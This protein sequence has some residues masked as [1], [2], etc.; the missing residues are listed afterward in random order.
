VADVTGDGLPDIVVVPAFGGGP[1]IRIFDA[2][3]GQLT[4]FHQVF[5]GTFQGGLTLATGDTGG[6][7]YS[8]VLVGAGE[9]GGPR[10]TLYD[11][12]LNKSI[13]NYFAY[14][15]TLR[16]GVSVSMGVLPG[17]TGADIVTGV[18]AG[19]GPQVNVYDGGTGTLLGTRQQGDPGDRSGIGVRVANNPDG[20]GTAIFV[21]RRTSDGGS[22]EDPIDTSF[23]D[24]DA[25]DS[26]DAERRAREIL[27]AVSAA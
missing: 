1:I 25:L 3:T 7:G 11:F 22:A 20:T 14:D 21:M 2:T 18:G 19:G 5:E 9:G 24:F 26:A 6:L 15:S 16:G 10:V 12:K 8:R 17:G 4:G 23:V 13:L 27:G